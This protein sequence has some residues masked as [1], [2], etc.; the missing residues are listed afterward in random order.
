MT[1]WRPEYATLFGVLARHD[2][3]KLFLSATLT[4]AERRIIARASGIAEYEAIVQKYD[5]CGAGR[6]VGRAHGVRRPNVTYVC[7]KV[8]SVSAAVISF[9]ESGAGRKGDGIVFVPFRDETER[10]AGR[11]RGHGVSAEHF[12]S[13]VATA[14]KLDLVRRFKRHSADAEGTRFVV[15]ATPGSFSCG[16]CAA[17][18]SRARGDGTRLGVNKKDVRFVLYAGLPPSVRDFAQGRCECTLAACA[19]AGLPCSA[20]AGRDGEAAAAVVLYEGDVSASRVTELLTGSRCI[21]DAMA[22][23]YSSEHAR[24]CDVAGNC[25]ACTPALAAAL[26]GSGVWREVLTR[27]TRARSRRRV[28]G[29]RSA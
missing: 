26:A 6:C 9:F 3:P 18:A 25:S 23:L 12:H 21:R 15:C 22:S 24:C 28:A 16:A 29:G 4:A 11:L 20:R 27:P 17:N 1:G 19:A 5:R 10:L 13:N 2:V 8:A 7:A 14:D